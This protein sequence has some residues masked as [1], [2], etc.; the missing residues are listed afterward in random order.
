MKMIQENVFISYKEIICLAIKELD[1]EIEYY[2]KK[3]D[4]KSEEA[5]ELIDNI[6]L[7]IRNKRKKLKDL[8]FIETG[9]EYD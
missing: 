8:Y 9:T 5:R 1:R 6:T 7:P 3:G 4:V 2:E